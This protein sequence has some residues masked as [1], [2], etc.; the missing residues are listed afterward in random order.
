M[1][2]ILRDALLYLLFVSL[3]VGLTSGASF[4]FF[5]TSY[6]G[7]TDEAAVQAGVAA[8]G[9]YVRSVAWAIARLLL[10]ETLALAALTF[11]L[12]ARSDI[13]SEKAASASGRASNLLRTLGV[14]FIVHVGWLGAEAGRH[15]GLFLTMLSASR[16][17]LV[18]VTL[19]RLVWPALVLASVARWGYL[20][21][22][23]RS[24][25]AKALA[26]VG[27]LCALGWS[28]IFELGPPERISAHAKEASA[29]SAPSAPRSARYP[30]ILFLGVDS[31]RPDKIDERT[32]PALARLC[33]ESVYF[34]NALVTLPRTAP[35][36][37][38]LL[39]SLPPLANG[40]ETMFPS[41]ARTRLSELAMPA[42]LTSLGYATSVSSEYAGEFFGRVAF[43][44]QRS[45]VP[46]VELEQI[47][48][49]GLLGREPAALAAAAELYTT[50]S[51]FRRLVPAP[52]PELL[53]GFAS[54]SHPHVLGADLFDTAATSRPWF[55]LLFYSQ[56]HFPYTSSSP[57]SDLYT[58]RGSN[59]ALRF[60]KDVT[61]GEVRTDQDRAQVEALYRGALAETDAAVAEVLARLESTGALDD[62]IVILTADHGEGLYECPACVGHG[63]NLTGMMTLRVP[64]AFRLPRRRFAAAEP[65]AILTH[66]S[67][68]DV[69]PTVLSLL[70]VP[71]PPVEE[72]VPLLL[73]DGGLFPIAS[74]RVFFSETGEWL[75]P[76]AAVPADRIDYPP[77]TALAAIER[78]RI[79]IEERFLPVIRAAKHR[80]AVAPPFKLVY[81]PTQN[82]V[83]WSLFDIERDPFEERDIKEANPEVMTKL[84]SLLVHSVLRFS[85]M[86]PMGDYFLTRPP[87]PLEEYY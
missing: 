76:T 26:V 74:D 4:Y 14:A 58:I 82:G 23:M 34:P 22:S 64:L 38:A 33:R 35:S 27:T 70:G 61:R 57:F 16:A 39:T 31:L 54:F 79:V 81:R 28:W 77:I 45:S 60:G 1:Q 21:V 5:G 30:N 87:P 44:F 40:V 37:A 73:P 67:Q 7:V 10:V 24:P 11:A 59:P 62:T 6:A 69:Y 43:G 52:V 3:V 51:F 18:W 66:V 84:R 48:G 68:L 8:Y 15:P 50:S 20:A 65:K 12:V 80:A 86:T 47:L 17:W 29:V 78:G 56:P 55:A 41:A 9:G 53:R 49:Q 42:H 71:R 75:W 2:R 25:M 46:R 32:S 13:A 36:W 83:V 85:H 63:D 72:G 19:S